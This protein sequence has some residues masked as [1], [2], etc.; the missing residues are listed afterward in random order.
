MTVV[1]TGDGGDEGFG[2]YGQPYIGLNGMNIRSSSKN[3][4]LRMLAPLFNFFAHQRIHPLYKFLRLRTSGPMLAATNG[5]E[6][7]INS[8]SA[9]SEDVKSLI[10]G[11]LLNAKDNEPYSNHLLEL[12]K[13]NKYENWHDAL[14]KIGIQSRLVD[15]FLYKVDSA[16]MNNSLETRCPFLDHRILSFAATLPPDLIIPDSTDKFLL[17][18]GSNSL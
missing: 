18:K 12:M 6:G 9:M 7:F 14:F 2:G 3:F 5:L 13:K 11:P 15:D 17:K 4:Y 8:K 16:S 1:L 10:F